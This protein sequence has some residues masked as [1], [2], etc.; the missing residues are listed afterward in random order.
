MRTLIRSTNPIASGMSLAFLIAGALAASAAGQPSTT[1]PARATPVS[2]DQRACRRA[3]DLMRH[4][5]RYLLAA[6]EKDGGWASQAGPGVSS[7][8]LKALMQTP[9]IGPQHAAVRRGIDFVM[10]FHHDDGGVYDSEGLHRN[11]ESS[12][13]LSMLAAADDPQYAETIAGLQRFLK[14]GQWDEGEGKPVDDPWYGGAGYGRHKRP[15]LSNT[16]MMLEALHDS[17]LP[18]DDPVYRKALVFVRRCQMLGETNDLD[19]ADGSTQGGFIYT[20]HNAGESKAGTITVA[21]R[22]ELRCYG[23]MS[24]AGFKS[25]VYAGLKRDDPRVAAVLGWIRQ[26]WTLD[27]NPN[28]PEKQSREGLYYFYHVFGRALDAWGAPRIEDATGRPHAWRQELVE[29][30]AAIQRD[31]G[32]WVNEADRWMEG[33]PALT[34]AYSLL[35]LQAACGGD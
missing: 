14:E 16:Q 22:T 5:A 21:G 32:S 13:A 20:P 15:D 1:Q 29:K 31:D 2:L 12:V 9:D 3:A 17:G 11:Y 10:T 23:S 27:H 35:A 6:Q 7:L 8:V 34:T 18:P 28:M 24:Y 30:L 19:L 33:L 25:L 4:G 26:H